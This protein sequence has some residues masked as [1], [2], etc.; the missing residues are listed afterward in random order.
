MSFIYNFYI[1]LLNQLQVPNHESVYG[2]LINEDFE[3]YKSYATINKQIGGSKKIKYKYNNYNFTIF[4]S[5]EPDRISF[6]IHN[7]NNEESPEVC[8]LLF[9]PKKDKYVYLETISY[10]Q[11]CSTVEMPKSKGGSLLLKTVL[12]FID[13]IKPKYDLQYIQLRDTS[14]FT[15]HK[16]NKKTPICNLYM[17][18]IGETWYGK[19]GFIPFDPIIKQPNIDILVDYKTNQKLVKLVKVKYTQLKKY[20]K[21]AST[22]PHLKKYNEKII[23]DIF[24]VYNDR[25]VQDFF[26]DFINKYDERCDMFNEIYKQIMNEIGIVDLYNKVYYKPL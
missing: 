14:T 17:L 21:M 5:E 26:K 8:V 6:S 4:Q 20:L 18:T 24:E 11:N 7:K 25:T 10:Y 12:S 19:Y 3:F 9:I 16:D 2:Q 15:C 1:N 13:E 22:K 23:N